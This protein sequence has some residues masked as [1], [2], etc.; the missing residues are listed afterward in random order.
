MKQKYPFRLGTTSYIIPDDILPNV[1]FLASKVDDVELVLFEVDDGYNNLPD[2][3]TIS[4]LYQ[5]GSAEDLS[6]T[7]HLPTDLDFTGDSFTL[8]KSLSKAKRTIEKT[9]PLAPWAYVLHLDGK[10][11]INDKKPESKQIWQDKA[12]SFVE[13]LNTWIGQGDLLAVE[14]LEKYPPDF[15]DEIIALA[16]ACR[17]IDIGHLWLDGH[18]PS[19]YVDQRLPQTRVIHIHGIQ[20]RDHKSLKFVPDESILQVLQQLKNQSYRGVVTI[21]VFDLED[22]ESSLEIFDRHHHIFEGPNG[23]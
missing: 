8:E 7:I 21:E 22:L 20:E 11:L 4:E 3:K 2:Q 6:Y 19:P 9:L 14:N 17:C 13:Q 23:N 10:H 18:D 1:R 16:D 5:I 15:W 12:L